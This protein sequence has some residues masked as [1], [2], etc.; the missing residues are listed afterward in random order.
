MHVNGD[1]EVTKYLVVGLGNPGRHYRGNRHNAG[2]M[3]I[4]F[5][6][7]AR[8]SSLSRSVS[9]ALVAVIEDDARTLILA[10]PQTYVNESGRSVAS[11]LRAFHVEQS[12]M[13]IA[14]DELDLE[15]GMLRMRPAGGSSGHRGM[16]SI[17]NHLG[18]QEFPRLRIGIGRPPG[19]RPAADYVLSNFTK[20]EWEIMNDVLTR[21]VGCIHTFLDQDIQI[22]MNQCN[23]AE[24]V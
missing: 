3:L 13:M 17:I 1:A 18:S 4:D 20:S 12:Q 19:R 21:A 8:Q 22:A 9:D 16:R 23:R 14:F 24:E 15:L 10:K 2:Y 6:L 7:E 11:L 5:L